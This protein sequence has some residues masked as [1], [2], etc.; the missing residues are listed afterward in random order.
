M[1]DNSLGH[2]SGILASE[3]MKKILITGGSG[4]LGQYLNIKANN[5]FEI[6]TLYNRN[7]GNCNNFNFKNADI[8]NF[9]LLKEI[10]NPFKP[11]VV[12]HAAA[13]TNPVPQPGQKPRRCAGSTGRFD[14]PCTGRAETAKE[15]QTEPQGEG[16]ANG[17]QGT[18]G[19]RQ[20]NAGTSSG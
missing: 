13:I 2:L 11:D 16:K 8:K 14:P 4:L 3:V 10:F 20:A 18:S 6:L 17:R 9:D 15:D 19:T 7:V 12:I 5:L 1:F